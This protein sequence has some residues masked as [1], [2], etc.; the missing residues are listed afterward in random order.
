VCI[1]LL[2]KN[3]TAI[4][5]ANFLLYTINCEVMVGMEMEAA[6]LV[7]VQLTIYTRNCEVMV[8]MEMEELS[9][10]GAD[11]NYIY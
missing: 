10:R 9:T 4:P 8:G 3:P 2:D 11:T 5:V 1:F 6:Q 7:P